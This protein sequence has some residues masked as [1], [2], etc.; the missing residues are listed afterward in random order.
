MEFLRKGNGGRDEKVLAGAG[1]DGSR[2]GVKEKGRRE[3]KD[4]DEERGE[5]KSWRSIEDGKGG[6]R[7]KGGGER[8]EEKEKVEEGGAKG[9]GGS[10]TRRKE[11]EVKRE[12]KEEEKSVGREGGKADW[13]GE[14][15]REGGWWRAPIQDDERGEWKGDASYKCKE[16][17]RRARMTE[18][19]FEGR[20]SAQLFYQVI[21]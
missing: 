11:T 1:E 12:K 10:R 13:Q 4:K 9:K 19:T 6:E 5:G 14:P 2:G 17:G 21:A 8:C 3:E 16:G 15:L 20:M 18:I 7:A